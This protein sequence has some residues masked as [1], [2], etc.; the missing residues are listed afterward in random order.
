[1]NYMKPHWENR[2]F[3]AQAML[4]L[5]QRELARIALLEMD[6]LRIP[7]EQYMPWM[8]TDHGNN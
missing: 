6:Q 8:E 1:M 4:A 7:L 3:E 5:A 2:Q